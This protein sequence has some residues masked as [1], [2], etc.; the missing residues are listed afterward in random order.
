MLVEAQLIQHCVMV[1]AERNWL[2]GQM[3]EKLLHRHTSLFTWAT[4]HLCLM[5]GVFE[6]H[7]WFCQWRH[8]WCGEIFSV[9]FLHHGFAVT[10]DI[11]GYLTSVQWE[12]ARYTN[13][14]TF[15]FNILLKASY[16][17]ESFKYGKLSCVTVINCQVLETTV[18]AVED[19]KL[20]F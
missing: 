17:F 18:E 14:A 15:R 16:R 4:S 6:S 11:G 9:S 12:I 8:A 19:T 7:F 5:N 20:D 13:F 2:S 1:N 10:S 3:S